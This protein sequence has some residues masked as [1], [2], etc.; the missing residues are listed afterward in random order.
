MWGILSMEEFVM[1]KKI[2]IKGAQ[3]FQALFKKKK[4]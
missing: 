4:Q 3:H 2:P 1:G